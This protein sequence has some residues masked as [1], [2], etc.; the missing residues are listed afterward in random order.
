MMDWYQDNAAQRRKDS[1]DRAAD[2]QSILFCE[3]DFFTM[4][5]LYDRNLDVNTVRA[6]LD[7]QSAIAECKLRAV[8]DKY[9]SLKTVIL[10]LEVTLC[11]DSRGKLNNFVQCRRRWWSCARTQVQVNRHHHLP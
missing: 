5:K 1:Q 9:S 8:D 10:G 6:L 2:Q 11:V 4:S 7:K 3:Y